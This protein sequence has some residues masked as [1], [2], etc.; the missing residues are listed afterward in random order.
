MK[1]PLAL[2]LAIAVLALC[3]MLLSVDHSQ[4]A[5]LLMGQ[6]RYAMQSPPPMPDGYVSGAEALRQGRR[7]DA[8]RCIDAGMAEASDSD[9]YYCYQTLLAKCYF[10]SMQSDS[11]LLVHHRLARYL[12][13]LQG[14]PTPLQR[15]LQVECEM[16]RGVY[17]TKMVGRMDS[18]LDHSLRALSLASQLPFYTD[19]RLVLLT[20]LADIYKQMGRYDASVDYYRRAMELADSVGASDDATTLLLDMGIASAYAAMGSFEQSAVWWQRAQ[21]LKPKMQPADLFYYLNNR[22]NDY[23]LQER[24]QESL[25]CFTE[26]DSLIA[27]NPDMTWERMFAHCNLCDLYIKTGRPELAR[28]MLDETEQFFT[29]QQQLIPLYY[30]TT[31]RIELALADHRPDLAAQIASQNPTPQWMIPEQKLL[32]QKAQLRLYEQTG[33]WQLY[34]HEQQDMD[35][36]RDSIAGDNMKMRF[37]ETLMRYEHQ[38]QILDKQHQIEEVQLSL[39]WAGALL[40]AAVAIIVLLVVLTILKQRERR[41]KEQQMRSSIA[42][43]R[44]ETV[45][46][47]IT[48]H[49]ISNALTAEMLAQM[50][51]RTVSLDPLVQLLHRGIEFTGVEQTTLQSELEF[52]AFYCSIESRSIGPDFGYEQLVAPDVDAASVMLPSMTIQILVENALKHGLKAKAP[53]PGQRRTVT[54]RATRQGK[55][56]LVEVIDNG[57]GLPDNQQ[58]GEHTGLRVVRQTLQMLNEQNKEMRNEPMRFSL[59][60]YRHDDGQ[61]GCRATIFL[62]DDFEY[63][64][65]TGGTS[66]RQ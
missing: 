48:P 35:R 62:P 27:S 51:G 34:A 18:A 6:G 64:L 19:N 26:L 57:V 13:S 10:S 11:F 22:G 41:L 63:R 43:L 50:Q 66:Q 45:R 56:T 58:W 59:S 30:L 60:N 7:A 23:Y 15:L 47:R 4:V 8:R 3:W 53:Q 46:N 65:T 25:L 1:K 36:L 61:T 14:I 16:Q 42:A 38:K 9:E 24:Y 49:F 31:L 32:R 5:S 17:E 29:A 21:Q 39:R 40:L 12:Q 54:V 55:G 52:I 44:M 28:P 33:Q 2:L 20:N 37:S